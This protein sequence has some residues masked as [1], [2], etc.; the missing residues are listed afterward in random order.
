MK[1]LEY[2]SSLKTKVRNLSLKQQLK[3]ICNGLPFKHFE[4]IKGLLKV[5]S[6]GELCKIIGINPRT[7]SR[8]KQDKRF[9]KEESD[10]ILRVLRVF[11]LAVQ[12]LA[13]KENA[14]NWLKSPQFALDN[15][16]PIDLLDTELGSHGIEDLLYQIKYGIFS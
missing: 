11:N 12:I 16:L 15:M 13:T 9:N 2:K 10:R 5:Q 1:T 14:I 3:E 7:L 4:D 6:D 8:R